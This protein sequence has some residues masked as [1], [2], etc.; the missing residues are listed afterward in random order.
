MNP[1]DVFPAYPAEEIE[2]RVERAWRFIG[3]WIPCPRFRLVCPVC[4]SEDVQLSRVG[5]GLRDNSPT[6]YRVDVS[7]KCTVCSAF[8]THGVPINKEVYDRAGGSRV[9]HWREIKEAL[10]ELTG[11]R[12]L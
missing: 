7:F 8:W 11:G 9:V 3:G 10:D 4:R 6:R 2:K 12:D 5:F 1:C